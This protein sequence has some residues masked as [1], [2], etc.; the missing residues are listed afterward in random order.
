ML[1]DGSRHTGQ[2]FLLFGSKPKA[3]AEPRRVPWPAGPDFVDGIGPPGQLFLLPAGQ[4]V[5][6]TVPSF[7]AD[8]DVGEHSLITINAHENAGFVSPFRDQ[9]RVPA[10]GDRNTLLRRLATLFCYWKNH[11]KLG[12]QHQACRFA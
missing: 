12:L 11:S 3:S 9:D 8:L 5:I 1:E 10:C 2:K 6:P 4:P 7:T